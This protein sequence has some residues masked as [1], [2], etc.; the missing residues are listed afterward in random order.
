MVDV[1]FRIGVSGHQQLGG[2]DTVDFVTQQ[3]KSLLARFQERA[4]QS[5][6]DLVVY[7]ALAMGADRLF[8]KTAL[9]FG[10]AVELVIPCACYEEIFSLEERE[11]YQLLLNKCRQVH[12]LPAW[13]C[14]DDAFLAAGRWLVENSDVVV[15]AWNGYP[16]AGKGGT[17]EVASCARFLGRPWF[18]IHTRLHTVKE[19]AG[20]RSHMYAVPRRDFAVDKQTVYQGDVLAVN[21]YRFRL[22]GGEEFERDVVERPES[23]LVLPLG[24]D[25]TVLLIEEPDLGAGTWQ[26]TI[27]GGR[28][29][30]VSPEGL[31]KQAEIELREETG[32]RPGRVEKLLD[33]YGHPG[34]MAHKVHL[35]VASDLEWDPLEM[36]DGEEIQ[37]LTLPLE[38]ALEITKQDYRCDPEAALALWL[39]AGQKDKI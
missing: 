14:S 9:D 30:D 4:R 16:A 38:E 19:Y 20:G 27:P 36:E 25:G 12:K 26:L 23:V 31:R 11:E 37:V 39:Y 35:F 24:R 29:P 7:S 6:R 33:L 34:Y 10:I 13:N 5:G 18:H 17:A 32:Y 8:V 3:F 15:L 2:P 22:P 21:R 1:A 28:A